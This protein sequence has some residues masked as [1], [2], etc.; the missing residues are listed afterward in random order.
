MIVPLFPRADDGHLP[1]DLKVGD[2]VFI[3]KY[4]ARAIDRVCPH[5]FAA[6]PPFPL[7]FE[8]TGGD[9]DGLRWCPNHQYITSQRFLC[10][11]D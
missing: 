7:Y 4:V 3:G 5:C 10:G 11:N 1:E 8:I 9:F 2:R 6:G